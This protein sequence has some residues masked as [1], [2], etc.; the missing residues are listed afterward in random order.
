MSVI[1]QDNWNDVGM[2]F[3]FLGRE[4]C[5]P[6]DPDCPKCP[7]IGCVLLCE[8]EEKDKEVESIASRILRIEI[9]QPLSSLLIIPL[10]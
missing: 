3:S 4:L 1:P 5:R 2:A 7:L 8:R 10:R 9:F 6:T